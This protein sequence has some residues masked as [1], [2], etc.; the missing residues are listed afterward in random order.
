MRARLDLAAAV[1]AYIARLHGKHQ[2]THS[3]AF[4]SGVPES[5]RSAALMQAYQL[6]LEVQ[7]FGGDAGVGI[8]R[9]FMHSVTGSRE[10]M[11][12]AA[13]TWLEKLC[14]PPPQLQRS[15]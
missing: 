3:S 8:V 5:V 14:N 10:L 15:K 11:E 7:L 4:L 9:H 2:G 6:L 12:E 13:G 1:L